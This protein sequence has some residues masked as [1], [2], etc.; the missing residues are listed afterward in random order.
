MRKGRFSDLGSGGRAAEG[1]GLGGLLRTL[2]IGTAEAAGRAERFLAD[3]EESG[4][5]W[6]WETNADGALTYLSPAL[7]RQLGRAEDSLIGR[8][9]EELL[10]V[11][12]CE[13]GNGPT[14][15]FHLGA[16]FQFD[17]VTVTPNGKPDLRWALS[18]KPAFDE[19]GRFLGFRGMGLSLSEQS[20]QDLRARQQAE[21]DTLTGLPNRA[22]MAAMLGQA[23]VNSA[24]RKEGCALFLIDLDRFKQ[25]ND[26]LGHPAGDALLKEV[27][28]RMARVLAGSGQVGR[29]GGDEFKAV[30][31]GVDE[32]GQLAALAERLIREVSAPYRI[33]GHSVTVGASVGIT[34]ARPGRTL[35]EALIKEADLALYAAKG[36][37]RGTYCFFEPSM[38]A[39]SIE[40]Q[41]FENDLRHAVAKGQLRLLYQP[42]VATASEDLLGFEALVRWAHPTR[43]V[44][45][46]AEFLPVAEA[47]G[48]M[49]GIGEWIIRTA[50][51]EAATWP[52]HLHL[53]LNLSV[54]QLSGEGLPGVLAGA[55]AASRLQPKRLEIEIGEEA[56]AGEDGRV[57]DRLEQLKGLGLRVALDDF[58]AG[59]TSLKSL[60]AVPLDLL[61][62]HPDL[63]RAAGPK[64]SRARQV[65]AGVRELVRN[66]GAEVSAEGAETLEDLKLIRAL[67]CERVQGFLF[68]RPLPPEEA[69]A[70]AAA[71]KP[72]Q[73]KE[74]AAARPPRHSLIR[75]GALILA[76]GAHDVRLRNISAGGAMVECDA[77]ASAGE[78]ARLDLG[79]GVQIAAV[80]RWVQDGRIGL[81]FA[82]GFDLARLGSAKRNA[83]PLV[84]PDY[85]QDDSTASSPWAG[86][87]ERLTI[88]DVRRS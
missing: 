47:N 59:P 84:R 75:R 38:H 51:A 39:E 57:L 83:T 12:E 48:M 46:P 3:L 28:R 9:F 16:R 45:P 88:R 72:L 68:A 79:N 87:Q 37:G 60:K 5:A 81:S 17:D 77:A 85:L 55:L 1:G 14:I 15:G 2:G 58:G 70:L 40:R 6:F 54:A 30:L 4:T 8:R 76:G 20:R 86:R 52:R 61:K 65:V 35:A 49:P 27:A 64:N 11:E 80:V 71:A 63:L 21:R 78:D 23:L 67:G 13:G 24:S 74:S 43:G 56:L 62:L 36:G 32:E 44:L 41:A 7:A 22:G 34:I 73:S 69:R 25:V 26:T 82:Q 19:V 18:G 53:A 31:P 10:L 29:L 42:I 50:C 66:L 33:Q